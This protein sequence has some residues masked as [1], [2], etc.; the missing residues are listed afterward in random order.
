RGA[1]RTVRAGKPSGAR[2]DDLGRASDRHAGDVL[3]P[4][5]AAKRPEGARFVSV[6]IPYVRGGY[7]PEILEG[8]AEAVY[9]HGLR[10]VLMPTQ[11]EHAR[12]VSLLDRLTQGGTLGAV[13]ILPEETTEELE[14]AMSNRCPFVVVDPLLPLGGRIPTVSVAH[15]SGVDQ[16]MRHLL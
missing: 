4:A 6:L 12:E 3:T 10:L 5:D 8:I 16:A 1:R 14:Q 15:R 7:F 11:H 2:N 13:V 9:E